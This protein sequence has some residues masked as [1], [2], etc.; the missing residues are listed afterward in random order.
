MAKRTNI[1]I[2]ELP[3]DEQIALGEMVY[4]MEVGVETPASDLV[5]KISRPASISLEDLK[6]ADRKHLE[7]IFDCTLP[8]RG[9]ARIQTAKQKGGLCLCGCGSETKSEFTIGHDAKMKSMLKDV[10]AGNTPKTP[11][12]K[13]FTKAT[14]QAFL[15]E[16]GW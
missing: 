9:N 2:T 13:G 14:A 15:V 1:D 3:A 6:P 7:R 4:G 16:R 5:G 10:V 11:N 12:Y 8:K